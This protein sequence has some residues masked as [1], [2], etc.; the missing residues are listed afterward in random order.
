VSD[1]PPVSVVIPFAGERSDAE[2]LRDA[3]AR[4][5]LGD[6]DEVIVGD[7][8]LGGVGA[9]VF[10]EP[11]PHGGSGG[12]G[13]PVRVA[14]ADRE[15][16]SYHGRNTAAASAKNEWILFM[17]ADCDPIP[18]LLDAYFASPAGDEVGALAGPIL[19]APDQ[20]SLAAR[21]ARARNFVVIPDEPGAIPTAPAGNLLVRREAFERFG[22]FVEG[23]RSGGDV[24]F[25]RRIQEAEWTLELRPEAVV[26]H[27]HKETL[28]Q[29]LRIVA[30]YAAGARWLDDR[31]PGIAPRWP[32]WPEVARAARD[33]ADR[34]AAGDLDEARYR[35]IDGLSL[36]A[37]NVGYSSGNLAAPW[38]A[39]G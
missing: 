28:P 3:I 1:R 30:R 34:W 11:V 39:A 36:V 25:C 14:R 4:V 31:Y 29:Y 27:P 22:G 33:A 8:S 20:S 15:R 5:R 10:G 13:S 2:R 38:K 9:G 37:H 7:N 32:L 19:H 17:D 26:F 16:S 12:G 23:I 18:D 21:Y 24:D 35:L 6:G